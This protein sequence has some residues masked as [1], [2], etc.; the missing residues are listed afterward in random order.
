MP[1]SKKK[2]KKAVH[3]GSLIS[4]HSD[5]LYSDEMYSV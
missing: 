3:L 5:V 2:R 1:V 4:V